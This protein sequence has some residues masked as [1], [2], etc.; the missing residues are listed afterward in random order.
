[1]ARP[2]GRSR[3]AT[4]SVDVA[5]DTMSSDRASDGAADV[6]SIDGGAVDAITDVPEGGAPG[7][8]RVVPVPARG[9]TYL[10]VFGVRPAD[11]TK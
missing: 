4:E 3:H 9:R 5:A 7:D 11:A 2:T 6:G 10:G 1:M 8:G